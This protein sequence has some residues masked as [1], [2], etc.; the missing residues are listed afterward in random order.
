MKIFDEKPS[1]WKDLQNKVAYILSSSGYEVE[2]PKKMQ[3]IRGEVEFDVFA[4]GFGLMIVCECKHWNSNVPQQVVSGFRTDI[5]DVGAHKGIIIAKKGFQSA[6][7]KKIQSTNVELNTWEEFLEQY[8]DRYLKA[9][10]KRFLK[11][12]S[13]LYRVASDKWEYL[14]YYDSLTV[15]LRREV[16]K[17]KEELLRIVL[18][19]SPLCIMLQYEE[20]EEIG[21]S[22]EYLDE[23]IVEAEKSFGLKFP[24]YYDFFEY[25]NKKVNDII[26]KIEQLYGVIILDV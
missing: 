26:T 1:N 8:R 19:F 9:Q 21:W 16:D 4:N 3:T 18:L 7:Y 2:T 5:Q 22:T 15:D 10:I 17:L 14:G 11:I 23:K 12:K 24:A 13:K 6:A 25:M 20:D